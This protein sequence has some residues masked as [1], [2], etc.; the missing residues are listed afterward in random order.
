MKVD[1]QDPQSIKQFEGKV[2]EFYW[3]GVQLMPTVRGNSQTM[4][5]L[6]YMLYKI[7]G[8]EP[9]TLSRYTVLPDCIALCSTLDEFKE[10]YDSCWDK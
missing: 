4:L 5:E 8:L 3:K 7:N 10:R 1:L 2:A 6:H 9:P